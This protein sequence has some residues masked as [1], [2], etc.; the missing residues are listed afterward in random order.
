M[1]TVNLAKNPLIFHRTL[2]KP[3]LPSLRAMA[4]W[5]GTVYLPF[6]EARAFIHALELEMKDHD[7]WLA[8]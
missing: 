1:L 4:D 8:Y 2:I 3:S 7:D 6:S 5:L